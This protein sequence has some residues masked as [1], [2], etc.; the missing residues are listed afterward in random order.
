MRVAL[1]CFARSDGWR[2]LSTGR[3]TEKTSPMEETAQ[4]VVPPAVTF[5]II[6][7]S[8]W[9]G[10]NTEERDTPAKLSEN[11]STGKLV[12]AE[13]VRKVT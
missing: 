13:F 11:L 2:V 10:R 8:I 12:L 3:E 9:G 5:V 6:A 7:G 4:I 1:V